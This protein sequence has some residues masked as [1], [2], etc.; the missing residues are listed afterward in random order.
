MTRM[1]KMVMEATAPPNTF[2]KTVSRNSEFSIQKTSK[3]FSCT[4]ELM[5]LKS[6]TTCP[7]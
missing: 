2:C 4:T 7:L 3:F 5:L 6:L 1:P